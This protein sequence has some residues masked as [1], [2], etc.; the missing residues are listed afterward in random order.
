MYSEIKQITTYIPKNIM[1]NK[2]F[3]S[4]LDTSDEW[5]TQMTGIKQRYIE[6]ELNLEEMIKKAVLKLSNAQLTNIDAVI[7][8]TMS[9]EMKSPSQAALVTKYIDGGGLCF[10][11]NS[12]C[13]GYIYG[14]ELCDNLIKSGNYKKILFINAEK[15]SN[16]LDMKDRNTAI[17]FG[18]AVVCNLIQASETPH[19]LNTYCNSIGND[20][21]LMVIDTLNMMG[22]NVFKFAVNTMYECLDKIDIDDI[23][24]FIFH[25]A[26]I[27]IINT[28]IKKYKLDKQKVLTNL[29]KYGNTSSAS[30]GLILNDHQFKPGDRLMLIGFGSGLS[31]G[32]MIYQV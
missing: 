2:D 16:V 24:Y 15:M 21:D 6:T 27:R 1:Y 29:E 20:R 11:I 31:Y 17:L 26:N 30:I 7:V 32:S 22:K 12:A 10:D 25:Q 18:D 13:S 8:S 5:I 28:V 14:L 9:S 3:E 19:V 23:D 4:F